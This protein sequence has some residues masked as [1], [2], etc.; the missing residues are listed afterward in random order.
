MLVLVTIEGIDGSGKSSLISSLGTILSDL[1]PVI[2]REP[3]STWVGDQ[4][5]RA[6]AERMDPVTEALLFA[7]DHAAHLS[8]LVRPSLEN[9]RLVISDR[10]SDSRYAYQQETLKGII[11]EPLEW[12]MTL[13][14]GWTI[15]PDLTFL[16]VLPVD[17]AL[18]RMGNKSNREHFENHDLLMRVQENYL[19]LAGIDP[20]RFVIIDGLKGEEEIA[21]FVAGIIR[22]SFA[23]SRSHRQP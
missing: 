17:E 2:T 15:R 4:V 8:T 19:T 20:S 18:S 6:V 9:G 11:R 14:S 5:R 7:A 3:G 23:Q 21:G 16:I 12:L 13:H 22:D 10:Y 1:S